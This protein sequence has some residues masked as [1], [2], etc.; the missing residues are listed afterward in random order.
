VKEGFWHCWIA[1][2]SVSIAMF[3]YF[4]NLNSICRRNIIGGDSDY[5]SI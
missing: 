3:D 4:P 2:I 5:P 1:S